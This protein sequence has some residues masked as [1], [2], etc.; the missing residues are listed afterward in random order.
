ML[1]WPLESTVSGMVRVDLLLRDTFTRV[2]LLQLNVLFC[3]FC[4]PWGEVKSHK[5]P[6]HIKG[7]CRSA[8]HSNFFV[9]FGE[10][11][12]SYLIIQILFVRNLIEISI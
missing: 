3:A 6:P 2:G 9:K 1:N 12:I 5:K 11:Q 4:M 7:F 8:I 10:I